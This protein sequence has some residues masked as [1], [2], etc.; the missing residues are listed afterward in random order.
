MPKRR[1]D[2]VTGRGSFD[3]LSFAGNAVAANVENIDINIITGPNIKTDGIDFSGLY[4]A[5]L[6]PGQFSAGV[7]GTRILGYDIDAWELG[8]AYNA[9]G[10]LNYTTSLARTLVKLK[11]RGFL[12]YAW[13]SLNV[14][15]GVSC[16]D[17]YMDVDRKIDNH[18]TH[19]IHANHRLLQDRLDVWA[20]VINLLD[21]D[22]P[23]VP[24]EMNY[25]TFTHNPY[26]RTFKV[27]IRY[28]MGG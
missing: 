21:E 1:V 14:R 15:Y 7:S 20:S 12:N 10:R 4:R 23:F 24:R 22:P 3:R 11:A 26:G 2:Q 9:L 17:D 13:D 16:A 28:R 18:V 6:G 25:D 5:P 19:N 8:E 27:G